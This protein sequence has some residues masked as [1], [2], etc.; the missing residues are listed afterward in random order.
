VDAFHGRRKPESVCTIAGSVFDWERADDALCL[1]LCTSTNQQTK[2]QGVRCGLLIGA[3]LR[4]GC[5]IS[6]TPQERES[7]RWLG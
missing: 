7:E 6:A 4:Q 3:I 2:Q 1:L 5:G